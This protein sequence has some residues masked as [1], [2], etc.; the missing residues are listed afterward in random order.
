M[1]CMRRALPLL[2]AGRALIGFG[3]SACLM[4]AFKAYTQW[5]ARERWPLVNGFQM[6]AG[7]L[8]ALAAASPER[9]FEPRSDDDI[10]ILYTGG[11]TGYPKGVVWRHEDVWRV[12]GGGIDFMTGERIEDEH[13]MSRQA[14]ESEPGVG[15]VLFQRLARAQGIEELTFSQMEGFLSAKFLVEALRR[16]GPHPTRAG[17][18]QAMENM[19][20][21]LGG[22]PI[23]L[24]PRE[25]S[26]GKFVD[27]LMFSKDG[28]FTR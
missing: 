6:A 20:T 10:Y 3:V 15:L 2:I 22:Y 25:H 16:A 8:G 5:F 27:L 1:A 4:A 23:R 9:D 7:G 11:T 14:A 17:L 18:I 24:S 21:S 26:S 28:K 19:Q 13:Q 12:L